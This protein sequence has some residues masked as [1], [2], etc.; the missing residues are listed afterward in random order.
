M[1]S[2]LICFEA[3]RRGK[4]VGLSDLDEMPKMVE[5]KEMNSLFEA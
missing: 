3:V 4:R 5:Q 1:K 2:I